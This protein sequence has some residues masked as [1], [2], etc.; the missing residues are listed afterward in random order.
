MM[1]DGDEIRHE[2]I[3]GEEENRIITAIPKDNY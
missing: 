1:V 2:H 3:G